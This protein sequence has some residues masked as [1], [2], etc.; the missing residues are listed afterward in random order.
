MTRVGEAK[1]G[2]V[3]ERARAVRIAENP[4]QDHCLLDS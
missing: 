1:Q 2:G 4:S 3:A